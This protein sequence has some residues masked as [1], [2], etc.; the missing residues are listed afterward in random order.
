KSILAPVRIADRTPG[1]VRASAGTR[2]KSKNERYSRCGTLGRAGEK[3]QQLRARAPWHAGRAAG[4]L[5]LSVRVYPCRT[6][7]GGPELAAAGAA[8]MGHSAGPSP[9][10]IAPRTAFMI[11]PRSVCV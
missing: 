11:L 4:L 8:S 7:A 10:R 6:F 2:G 9:A 3:S 5:N 1:S